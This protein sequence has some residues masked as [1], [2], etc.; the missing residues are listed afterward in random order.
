MP[1]FSIQAAP[2]NAAISA[3][4]AAAD[5]AQID[6]DQ[7]LA[8]AGAAQGTANT[9]D[10]AASLAN[11]RLVQVGMPIK[12]DPTVVTGGTGG[13]GTDQYVAFTMPPSHT[14]PTTTSN[15]YVFK[16]VV[17]TRRDDTGAVLRIE[18]FETL[19]HYDGSPAAEVWT[20]LGGKRELLVADGAIAG[21]LA[22]AEDFP[23]LG[24]DGGNGLNSLSLVSLPIDAASIRIECDGTLAAA[25]VSTV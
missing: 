14:L 23:G 12:I 16:G 7:A 22:D 4:Q 8:D 13:A 19:L 3:A 1:R 2:T 25:G 21:F 17:T 10:T 5:Q 11:A 9:A 15:K 6:A 18:S 20:V 24:D